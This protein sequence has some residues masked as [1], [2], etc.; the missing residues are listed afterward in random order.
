LPQVRLKRPDREPEGAK[1]ASRLRRGLIFCGACSLGFAGIAY[2]RGLHHFHLPFLQAW[3][4]QTLA[5][6]PWLGDQSG[7]SPSSMSALGSP[8]AVSL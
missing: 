7:G 1:T 8:I 6:L 2:L 5:W 3:L 4:W